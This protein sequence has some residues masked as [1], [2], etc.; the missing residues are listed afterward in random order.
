MNAQAQGI[1]FAIP[2][3]MAKVIAPLLQAVRQ[4]AAQLDG[5]LSRS[6]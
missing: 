1:G 3:N 6:R 4:G 2:I 5:R